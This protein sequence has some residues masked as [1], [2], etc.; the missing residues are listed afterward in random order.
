MVSYPPGFLEDLKSRISVSDVVSRKVKLTRRGREYVG[1]SPFNSEKTPSFTVND[2]KGFFHCFSS[3]EHGDIFSFLIKTEGL[4]FPEAV[5][6][7]AE[8]AGVDVP[9]ASPEQV[10]QAKHSKSL[11]EAV[12]LAAHFFENQLSMPAGKKA[13]DYLLD[14]GLKHETI[15]RFRL[16]YA[17]ADRMSVLAFLRREGIS[18]ELAVEAGLARRGDDGSIYGYFKDRVIFTI[19]DVQGRA[20]GFGARALGE[21]QPKYLNSPDNPLFHK[22]E[23]LYGLDLAREHAHK[24]G[25]MIVVEGYMDVIALSEA[26]FANVVAP[27]G[28]AVTEGQIK[29][30]WRIVAA[31]TLCLDGDVAGQ[32]AARRAALR[33]VP[34]LEPGRTLKFVL[35]DRGR[36]PD[37][38]VRQEG[39][40]LYTSP[41]PRD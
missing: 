14:R 33:A 5:E 31:P 18:D 1:L 17:P 38:L 28:T 10:K 16:G 12:A 3:G 13:L 2:V 35:L 40:L 26:G 39:C 29:R 6:T 27:L 34:I 4:S 25:E 15:K 20:I 30:L 8:I 11:L 7:V 19:A 23:T 36:D 32:K 24:S 21:E 41:S 37:D 22:G 9:K